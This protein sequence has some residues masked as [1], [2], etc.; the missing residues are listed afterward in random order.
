VRWK[1]WNRRRGHQQVVA[2]GYGQESGM[3]HSEQD[4]IHS[5]PVGNDG[6]VQHRH[7]SQDIH[8]RQLLHDHLKSPISYFLL[9]EIN[10]VIDQ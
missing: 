2:V 8:M 6:P 3:E 5:N 7:A 10:S 9:Y 1:E 4:P